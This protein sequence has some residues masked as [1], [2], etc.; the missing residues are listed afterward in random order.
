MLRL[1][2]FVLLAY[3]VWRL[4]ESALKLTGR[5]NPRQHDIKGRS[6]T[7]QKAPQAPFRDIRD[8]EFEDLSPKKG[9]DNSP[10]P[11]S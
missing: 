9:D 7:A 2:L 11:G 5:Q 4:L 1:I 10:V 6:R 3:L 8:A